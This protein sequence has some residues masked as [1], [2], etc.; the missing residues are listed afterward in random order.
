MG[1]RAKEFALNG[2]AATERN[3]KM[4]DKKMKSNSGHFH[5]HFLVHHLLVE[6]F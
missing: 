1:L 4:V 3:K 5:S 6:F 2:A